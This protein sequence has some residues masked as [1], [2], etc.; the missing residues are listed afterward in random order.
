MVEKS[1]CRS[2]RST[3]SIRLDITSLPIHSGSAILSR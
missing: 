3:T 2:C 1:I